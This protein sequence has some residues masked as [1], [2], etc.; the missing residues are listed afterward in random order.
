MSASW[1]VGLFFLSNLVVVGLWDM[2]AHASGQETVSAVIR[3]WALTHR[4][5]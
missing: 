3:D 2:Y 5:L 1:F 4:K